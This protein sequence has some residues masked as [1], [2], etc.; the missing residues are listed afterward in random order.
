[1]NSF[2]V[3]VMSCILAS[4]IARWKPINSI[5]V[6]QNRYNIA[7]PHITATRPKAI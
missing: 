4:Y 5:T 1:M 6:V 3:S 7:M 2:K